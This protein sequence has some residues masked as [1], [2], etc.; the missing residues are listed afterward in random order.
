MLIAVYGYLLWGSAVNGYVFCNVGASPAVTALKLLLVVELICSLP[1]AVRP[2]IE[3]FEKR[4]GLERGGSPRVEMQRNATRVLLV[5]LSYCVTIAVP[6]FQDCLTLVGGVA[7]AAVGFVIPPAVHLKLLS[8]GVGKLG[9]AE[10]MGYGT[11]A[12]R[13][14]AMAADAAL[15]VL[16]V[17]I[18]VWTAYAS[19]LTIV[20]RNEGAGDDD[21]QNGC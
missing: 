11:E 13:K 5:L 7:G 16:G 20:D 10:T 4:L 21:E 18:Q 15:V 14:A 6:V 1:F 8:S 3:I 12:R 17:G 19:V 9:E 2:N